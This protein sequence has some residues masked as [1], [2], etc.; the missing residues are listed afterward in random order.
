MGIEKFLED[1]IRSTEPT[2]KKIY[3]T[4]WCLSLLHLGLMWH[5]HLG[6]RPAPPYSFVAIHL[7]F[8][9]VLYAIPKEHDRWQNNGSARKPLN[10]AGHL[11]VILWL[12]SA[13]AMTLVQHFAWLANSGLPDGMA[14]TTIGL[15]LIFG[16]T[17]LSKRRYTAKNA[18]CPHAEESRE[19]PAPETKT[20]T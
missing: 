17:D 20:P 15:L 3:V 2:E 14:E 6:S 5:S 8:V 10:R 1:L 4:S 13:V 16:A 11:L 19:T 12:S 18:P 7:A 9:G